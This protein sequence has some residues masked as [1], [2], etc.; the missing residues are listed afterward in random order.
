M[1][2][3]SNPLG[4]VVRVALATVFA[5]SSIAA[6]AQPAAS[7]PKSDPRVQ[8][9]ATDGDSVIDVAVQR[10]QLTHLV[11]PPGESFTLPPATGQGARCDDE[12]HHW[13]IVA[14]GRDL[15]IKAKPAARTNNLILVTE[16]RRF[17][18]ELRA[19]DRGG[20]MR[21]SLMPP[22]AAAG[23]AVSNGLPSET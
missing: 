20:L 6:S 3:S 7:K 9:L 15:F 4:A 18:L 21:L 10:G 19:V 8:E 5:L 14:Q 17:A 1:R 2:R 22:K 16:R 12:T 13:C 11:L 23:D